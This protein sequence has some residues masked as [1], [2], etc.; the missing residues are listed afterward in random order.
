ALQREPQTTARRI[1]LET[2]KSEV[3]VR[4]PNV[5]AGTNRTLATPLRP[6]LKSLT[7]PSR[8][9]DFKF[10]PRLPVITG[11]ATYRGAVP[12]DGI[13]SGQMNAAGGSI[14]IKQRPRNGKGD[15]TPELNGEISFKDMLRV[16]GHVAGKLLSD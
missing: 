3:P 12:V 14:S 4:L 13:I 8:Q 9:N 16:N 5:T 6:G 1:P 10:Q 2:E 15:R 11:E 7:P